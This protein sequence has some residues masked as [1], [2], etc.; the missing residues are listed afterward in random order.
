MKCAYRNSMCRSEPS[1]ISGGKTLV[2]E[3]FSNIAFNSSEVQ[4]DIFGTGC[5]LAQR[6][7]ATDSSA[8]LSP[9]WGY[10]PHK[11]EFESESE[12][13][14][15]QQ[16]D[17]RKNCDRHPVRVPFHSDRQPLLIGTASEGLRSTVWAK[18]VT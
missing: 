18:P 5:E 14:H 16:S 11:G 13:A 2:F 1:S 15:N 9:L 4:L 8:T 3:A 7:R 10:P 12:R 17:E 6:K